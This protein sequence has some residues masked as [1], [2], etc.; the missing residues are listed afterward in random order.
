M[1]EGLSGV[2][3]STVARLL[4]ER[5]GARLYQT[6]PKIFRSARTRFDKG[7]V[8]ASRFLFYLSGIVC[9]SL[10]VS[11][12][13]R[14]VPVVCDRYVYTTTCFHAAAGVSTALWEKVVSGLV[15][16]PDLTVL[17][18]CNDAE[19][20]RRLSGRGLTVN[21]KRER[22]DGLDPRFLEEYRKR[23]LPEIDNS[24]GDPIV[25]VNAVLQMLGMSELGRC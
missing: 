6:P 16:R 3:K 13:L 18:V 12:I 5:L 15:V 11:R 24:S 9:S 20:E 17:I 1:V 25:A 8:N 7:P 2:G 14:K 22:S 21:D 4:S 19:R 23:R 10:E